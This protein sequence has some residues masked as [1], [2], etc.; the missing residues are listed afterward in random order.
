MDLLEEVKED[1]R[2]TLFY[3]LYPRRI[4][5]RKAAECFRKAL[6]RASFEVIMR[7]LAAYP[8]S[9]DRQ[10]I[11]HPTTWL[12]NDRWEVAGHLPPPASETGNKKF[13]SAPIGKTS[14]MDKY[15]GMGICGD[16]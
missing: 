8:F 15:D 16:D 1:P 12:N 11:P 10:F 2:F 13:R 4:D 14:W 3:S 7:G 5:R 9:P 6:T